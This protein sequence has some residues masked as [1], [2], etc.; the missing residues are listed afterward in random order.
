MP[1]KK[2]SFKHRLEYSLFAA[3]IFFIKCSPAWFVP[4]WS[5]ILIFFL[6]KGSRKHS[7]LIA[8]NLAG[9]FP[10]ASPECL[11][12]LQNKIYSHFGRM[13]VEIARTFARREP[14]AVLARSRIL[15]PEVI[16]KALQKK[17]GLVIFSAHFGNWE[18]IPLILH[19]HLGRDILSIAR[20]MDNPL[21]EKKVREFREAMGSKIIYKKG[22]LRTI[23]TRLGDN[24]IVYLLI[25]QNTVPRE[26]SFVDFFA[27][28]ASTNT[29]VA[30]LYLKKN[31]PAVPVFLHYEGKEIILD[32]LPEVDF[33]AAAGGPDGLLELTQQMTGL[34]ET[35]IKEFHEQW[36]WFHDR[37]K[38]RPQGAA[39]ES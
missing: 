13:F 29:T 1:Q 25:D 37:W 19:T 34:I 38:T 8:K 32:V 28:K 24:Q 23:L 2:N 9:A 33:S 17:R 16:E 35:Q 11:E 4:A 30:Q 10:A 7:R 22:S 5:K 39:H 21:L 15:H 31:I 20:P 26:G 36:F 12:E 3:L 6:K 27:R 14:Q 18:W